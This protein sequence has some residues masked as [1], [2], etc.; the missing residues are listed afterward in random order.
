V[1]DGDDYAD[2]NDNNN[3]K[4]SGHTTVDKVGGMATTG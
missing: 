3:D 4:G 2:N 1:V